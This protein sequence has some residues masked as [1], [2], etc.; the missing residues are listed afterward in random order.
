[1]RKDHP[2]S[3]EGEAGMRR[4][5]NAYLSSAEEVSACVYASPSVLGCSRAEGSEF[6]AKAVGDG[7][8]LARSVLALMMRS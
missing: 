2:R 6:S 7:N 4:R 1:M 8:K 3:D 5:L